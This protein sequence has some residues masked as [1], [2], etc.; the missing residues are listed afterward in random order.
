MLPM[1]PVRSLT[2]CCARVR[3]E[4]ANPVWVGTLAGLLALRVYMVG[5]YSSPPNQLFLVVCTTSKPVL[6]VWFLLIQDRLSLI[7]K[8]SIGLRWGRKTAVG[9]PLGAPPR[10]LPSP[11]S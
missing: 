9:L 5:K 6:M 11:D 1:V 8:A 10:P 2:I 3:S 7:E 4:L